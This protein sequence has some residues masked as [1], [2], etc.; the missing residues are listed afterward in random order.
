MHMA[1]KG[2]TARPAGRKPETPRQALAE[3]LAVRSTVAEHIRETLEAYRA[4]KLPKPI[5]G[6]ELE[7]YAAAVGQRAQRLT[8]ILRLRRFLRAVKENEKG[9]VQ[10][11]G[12]KA[13]RGK[14]VVQDR[15]DKIQERALKI[16]QLREPRGPTRKGQ[17]G[18]P[19]PPTWK[20]TAATVGM[21]DQAARKLHKRELPTLPEARAKKTAKEIAARMQQKP[22]PIGRAI[23]RS[24]ALG[25]EIAAQNRRAAKARRRS[26]SKNPAR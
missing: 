7:S 9:F 2:K 23:A 13:G 1:K 10:L 22:P 5:A 26:Q 20:E 6:D 17:Q 11:L 25:K 8:D 19:A 15:R 3:A 24:A 21:T 12:V 16:A 4:H 18:R 14:P